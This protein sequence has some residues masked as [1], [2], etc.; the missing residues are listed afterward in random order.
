MHFSTWLQ[1]AAVFQDQTFSDWKK[2]ADFYLHF[3]SLL[4][5]VPA[6]YE[7]KDLKGCA[8]SMPRRRRATQKELQEGERQMRKAQERLERER[9]EQQELQIE[10][11]TEEPNGS[12]VV[13]A[14]QLMDETQV[15]Q[16][17]SSPNPGASSSMA[18]ATIAS[19]KTFTPARPVPDVTPKTTTKVDPSQVQVTPAQV[20]VPKSPTPV[21][22]ANASSTPLK[23]VG[24]PAVRTQESV[25]P[26]FST[27]QLALMDQLQQRAPILGTPLQQTPTPALL[28]GGTMQ[29]GPHTAPLPRPAFLQQ[30]EEHALREEVARRAHEMVRYQ[31]H[32]QQS[33]LEKI[34]IQRQVELLIEENQKLRSRMVQ[35]EDSQRATGSRFNTP[36]SQQKDAKVRSKKGPQDEVPP[37]QEA[38]PGGPPEDPNSGVHPEDQEAEDPQR[39]TQDP[40]EAKEDRSLKEE[41]HQEMEVQMEKKKEKNLMSQVHST[42]RG[43][44]PD[45]EGGMTSQ[46]N[47]WSS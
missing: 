33:Q 21:P 11:V 4:D 5:S 37:Q 10:D 28:P 44:T 15:L 3:E 17:N 42:S 8:M 20:P 12:A 41:I 19:P 35:L 18:V 9:V 7:P 34:Q 25:Q 40:P 23:A 43:G 1:I 14:P 6:G 24:T 30:E 27:E 16:E 46:R 38:A 13:S 32:F 45:L 36:E 47:Q 29:Q 22:E 2:K 31:E 26:L 39:L